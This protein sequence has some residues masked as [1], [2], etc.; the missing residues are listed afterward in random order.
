[1]STLMNIGY[2]FFIVLL[3]Y[4]FLS[5][6]YL[7]VLAIMG[8]FF[9]SVKFKNLPPAIP[10]NRIAVLV[11]AYKEDRIIISTGKNLVRQQ[12]P[13][14][15]FDVYIIADSFL[16]ET[17][18]ELQKLPLTVIPVSFDKSTKTKSLNFAFSVI[19]IQY[20]IAVICD[21]DNIMG[22]EFLH[23]INTCFV[24]GAVAVQAR[25]VAK[26]LD[27]DFAILDACSE[28]INNNIF[29]KGANAM[30]LSSSVIGSGMAFKY[31]M[32]K[33]IMNG[34]SAVGG[35][36]KIMQLK[37]VENGTKIHYIENA[38]IFDEKV[39]SAHHFKQQRKRWV[40]SQFIYL[41]K[42]FKQGL[43]QLFRGNI[44]YFNLSIA[45]NIILPRG[46]M[47][48]ILPLLFTASLFVGTGHV[49][50]AGGVF[51]MYLA[52]LAFALPGELINRDL[53][54]AVLKIPRAVFV[55][56]GTLLHLRKANKQFIHTLHTKTE[57]SNVLFKESEKLE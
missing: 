28:G 54:K 23:Q 27:T 30:G 35:F 36:D 55:M 44:S 7:F 11:P 3:A 18:A 19:T 41:R 26:N 52:S 37:I 10:S 17:I 50:I 31:P 51:L 33:D 13:K 2:F 38:L 25:R 6:V 1:M 45:N 42:F 32:I 9:P 16:P 43:A 53:G 40:S 39:D 29:R 8:R 15:L 20:D 5:A 57:V 56:I 14:D 48:L 49:V 12:Y 22:P 4:C 47:F 21:A 46:F 34:I 24:N